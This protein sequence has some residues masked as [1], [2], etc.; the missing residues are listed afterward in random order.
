VQE[1]VAVAVALPQPAVERHVAEQLGVVL[2]SVGAEALGQLV[3]HRP[4]AAHDE[5]PPR[6]LAPQPREHVGEE[7]RVLLRVEPADAE[8]GQLPVVR[9]GESLFTRSDV[10]LVH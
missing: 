5:P 6:V 3:A 2:V 1:H 9:T 10:L 7:Q 8:R 4:D